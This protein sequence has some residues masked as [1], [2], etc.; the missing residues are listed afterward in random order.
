MFQEVRGIS[1]NDDDDDDDDD[2]TGLKSDKGMRR[3]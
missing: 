2:D 1:D 3:I